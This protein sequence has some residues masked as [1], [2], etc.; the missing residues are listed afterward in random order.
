MYRRS[1]LSCAELSQ[2]FRLYHLADL[3]PTLT[4][5][6]KNFSTI[7]SELSGIVRGLRQQ[8]KLRDM[9]RPSMPSPPRWNW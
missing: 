8:K 4:G 9:S 5:Q 2:R 3:Y 7:A 6:A 1:R